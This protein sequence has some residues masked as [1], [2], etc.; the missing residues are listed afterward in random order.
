MTA[1]DRTE[2]TA[3]ATGV[4]ARPSSID[5]AVRVVEDCAEEMIEQATTGRS[6]EVALRL[7]GYFMHQ[8]SAQQRIDHRVLAYVAEALKEA[9]QRLPAGGVF[10]ATEAFSALG[11]VRPKGG[12]PRGSGGKFTE[13][14]SVELNHDIARMLAEGARH[15]SIQTELAE[16]Y[17]CSEDTIRHRLRDLVA[18][19][20]R[21]VKQAACACAAEGL[22]AS[23]QNFVGAWLDPVDQLASELGLDRSTVEAVA[24]RAPPFPIRPR[25]ET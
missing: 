4:E 10:A 19:A 3:G 5:R 24:R 18:R 15:A 8:V 6:P 16:P 7:L 14:E 23:E 20:E 22:D 9:V 2:V 1:G 12:R 21:A 13:S 17:R 25:E 11:L